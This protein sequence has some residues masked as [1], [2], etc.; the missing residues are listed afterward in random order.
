MTKTFLCATLPFVLALAGCGSSDSSSTTGP[1]DSAVTND[2]APLDTGSAADTGSPATDSAPETATAPKFTA[3]LAIP[4]SF[5]GETS[6][7]VVAAFSK[8]PVAGPP[9]GG[10]LAQIDAPKL[11]AGGTFDLEGDITGIDGK[12]Y[13]LVVVYMKGGG[14]FSP[15]DGVDYD[16]A[17]SMALEFDGKKSLDAGTLTLALHH[18]GD[19]H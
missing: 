5:S 10:I 2:S 6:K 3:K 4:A 14:T 8:L 15:K 16:T 7:L 17:T 12:Y 1:A 9:D 18:M 11:T 13:V 19:G